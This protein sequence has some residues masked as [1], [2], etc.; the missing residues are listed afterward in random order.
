MDKVL[1]VQHEFWNS[2]TTCNFICVFSV[3]SEMQLA[4]KPYSP[5]CSH[6][7]IIFYTIM[8]KDSLPC[9]L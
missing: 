1:N 9:L 5:F 8:L 4:E 2:F 3:V 6:Y 7:V